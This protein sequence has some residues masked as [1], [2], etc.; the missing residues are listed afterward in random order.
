MADAPASRLTRTARMRRYSFALGL[1][2]ILTFVAIIAVAGA[3]S[4]STTNQGLGPRSHD[5]VVDA[6]ER[7]RL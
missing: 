5:G 7:V 6:A 3:T 1:L 2:I 4:C